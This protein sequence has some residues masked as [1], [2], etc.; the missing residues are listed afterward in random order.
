[1]V[2]REALRLN[3][4]NA[5]QPRPVMQTRVPELRVSW[6]AERPGTTVDCT[7]TPVELAELT[8]EVVD[9]GGEPVADA[10]ALLHGTPLFSDASGRLH[11]PAVA[12]DEEIQLVIGCPNPLPAKLAS[13]PSSCGRNLSIAPL[14]AGAHTVLEVVVGQRIAKDL[15][16]E[17]LQQLQDEHTRLR[18]AV[19]ADRTDREELEALLDTPLSDAARSLIANQDSAGPPTSWRTLLALFK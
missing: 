5:N 10:I 16:A 12:A 3:L 2:A 14:Q 17:E 1:M 9:P 11:L 18:A 6:S 4:S 19:A 13:S 7:I 15:T 8:L